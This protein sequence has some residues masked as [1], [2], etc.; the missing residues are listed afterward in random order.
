MLLVSQMSLAQEAD[1]SSSGRLIHVAYSPSTSSVI[2]IN[3]G[4]LGNSGGILQGGGFV[5]S[6]G[7]FLSGRYNTRDLMN[8]DRLSAV[9]GVSLQVVEFAHIYLGG[10]YGSY[11]YPSSSVFEADLEIT[12]AEI[13]SGLILKFGP[14]T[15]HGGASVLNFEHIDFLGG[16]GYTF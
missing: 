7:L 4:L 15:L 16:I 11:A 2:G 8:I 6:G 12:G 5:E 14:V 9:L 13:E 3:G 1:N 10:G